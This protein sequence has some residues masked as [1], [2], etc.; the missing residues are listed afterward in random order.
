ML[1]GLVRT[2]LFLVLVVLLHQ[3]LLLLKPS[4]RL[5]LVGL[6]VVLVHLDLIEMHLLQNPTFELRT[7]QRTIS[8]R[9]HS[10]P[11]HRQLLRMP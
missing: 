8:L 1:R 6:V 2:I 7:H 9:S 11:L 3:F 5:P 10:L 4:S